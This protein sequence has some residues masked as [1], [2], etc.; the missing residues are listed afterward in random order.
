MQVK[1]GPII[2]NP[3]VEKISEEA[4]TII[5]N[6]KIRKMG[7]V[8]HSSCCKAPSITAKPQKPEDESQTH[9][10]R[11]EHLIQTHGDQSCALLQT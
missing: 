7:N 6:P 3:K 2:N 11:G 1:S 5:A 10:N 4:K 8:T 9:G